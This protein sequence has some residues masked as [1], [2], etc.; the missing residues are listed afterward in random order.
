MSTSD[1]PDDIQPARRRSEPAVPPVLRRGRQHRIVRW[2][3][4]G[5]RNP[6]K[7]DAEAASGAPEGRLIKLCWADTFGRPARPNPA[8]FSWSAPAPAQ[9]L[10]FRSLRDRCEPQPSPCRA[11]D[12]PPVPVLR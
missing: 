5:H 11:A 1:K 10:P 7:P 8:G 2:I 9:V 3:G 12:Q 4:A 6:S